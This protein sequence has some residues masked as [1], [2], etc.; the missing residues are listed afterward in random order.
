MRF[1]LRMATLAVIPAAF[2]SIVPASRAGPVSAS[3]GRGHAQPTLRATMPIE[4]QS[5]RPTALAAVPHETPAPTSPRC[6]LGDM[7]MR[8]ACPASVAL[9]RPEPTMATTDAT[10]FRPPDA[11][12]PDRFAP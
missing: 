10:V 2:L 6:T 4:V 12:A 3:V 5:V 7:P 11:L 8:S 9:A 1:L